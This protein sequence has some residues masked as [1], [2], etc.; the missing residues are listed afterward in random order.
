MA[1]SH[2]E[3]TVAILVQ[4]QKRVTGDTPCQDPFVYMCFVSIIVL[5]LTPAVGL[6]ADPFGCEDSTIC[7][8]ISLLQHGSRKVASSIS[9]QGEVNQLSLDRGLLFNPR[10]SPEW[11]ESFESIDVNGRPCSL[12][13]M[14]PA[15]RAPNNSYVQRS[16]CGNSSYW[17]HPEN[18][19]LPLSTF[20]R[21]ATEGHNETNGWCELNFEKGC[22]DAVYNQDYMMFAKSVRWP[23]LPNIGYGMSSYDQHFCFYNGWLSPEIRALQH[24]SSSCS[25]EKCG[26]YPY[27]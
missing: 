22:A 11:M 20:V 1:S 9:W 25:V 15:E 17:E 2:P 21:E 5:V 8:A 4:V 13:S 14:P 10:E 27:S 24:A 6:E 7:Q 3:P 16:D 26:T 23:S 19:K 12:C 18:G